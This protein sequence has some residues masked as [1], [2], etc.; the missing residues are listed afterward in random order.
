MRRSRPL[1]RHSKN[2]TAAAIALAALPASPARA[3]P[4]FVTDD[5]EPT[6]LKHWEIYNFVSGTREFGADAL[7]GGVDLNYGGAR[8][9]QLTAT[10]PLHVESGAPLDSGSVE[11][12]VKYRFAHQ[13]PDRISADIALFPRVILPTARGARRA[14]VLLPIWLQRDFG[15]WSLFG[16]AGYTLNPGPDQ[17]NYWQ[18]GLVLTRQMR[19]GL[20]LGLEYYGQARTSVDDRPVHGANLAAIVHIHGPFSWL[21]SAGKGLNRPQTIAYTALKL[22]L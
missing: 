5:P 21:V 6:D 7:D 22:D 3:G 15:K 13:A 2:L 8:D 9:L 12:A 4:P 18:Q 11:L 1:F 17:R 20:Q 14:Q 10:L 16:G 19:P